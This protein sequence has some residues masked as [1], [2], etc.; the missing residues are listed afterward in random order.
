MLNNGIE[1]PIMLLCT[2]S[3]GMLNFPLSILYSVNIIIKM[4]IYIVQVR[5]DNCK[6]SW[7][8]LANK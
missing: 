4:P 7:E 5:G 1:R 2:V 8:I 3:S 6:L